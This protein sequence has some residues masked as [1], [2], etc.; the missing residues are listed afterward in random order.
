[1]WTTWTPSGVAA[2][3]RGVVPGYAGWETTLRPTSMRSKLEFLGQDYDTLFPISPDEPATA[4]LYRGP[5]V[6]AMT[7]ALSACRACAAVC[8][9]VAR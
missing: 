3:I 4:V 9:V 6:A 2:V 7:C 8:P 1:M 5:R